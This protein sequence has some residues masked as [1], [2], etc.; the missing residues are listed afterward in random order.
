MEDIVFEI[1]KDICGE[2]LRGEERVNLFQTG[3]LDS[4]GTIE[5]FVAIEEKL[6]II[7]DPAM[8][9]RSEIDTP[10]KIVDY[11]NKIGQNK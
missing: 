1:L 2:D 10:E 6:N 7:L 5:L 9:N 8:V 11:L 4:L 3:R